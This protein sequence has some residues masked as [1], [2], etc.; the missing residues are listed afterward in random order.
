MFNDEELGRAKPVTITNITLTGIDAGNYIPNTTAVS[1]GDITVRAISAS[2]PV[3]IDSTPLSDSTPSVLIGDLVPLVDTTVTFTRTGFPSVVCSFIPQSVTETCTT[4]GLADGTWTYRARQ[5]IAGLMVAASEQ[6]TITIDTT[7]PLVTKPVSFTVASDSGPNSTDGITN[8][9][10]PTVSVSEASPTDTVVVIATSNA[11]TKQCTFT[12]TA[13][14]RT[15]T[16]P[17]LLDGNWAISAVISD[18]AQNSS[19]STPVFNVMI[20][21]IVPV[22]GATPFNAQDNGALTSLD[23]TP[24][25]SVTGVTPGEI[26]TIKGTRSGSDIASC[27]FVAS[28]TVS[29]CDMSPMASGT[30]SLTSTISDLAGNVSPPSAPLTIIISAGKAPMTI[31]RSTLRPVAGTNK[32]EKVVAVKFGTSAALAGIQSVSFIVFDGNGAVVRRTTVKINPNDTGTQIVIPRA[33]KGATVRVITTNQCG[34]SEGAP[35]SFNVR[36]GQTSISI[37]KKTNIPTL[38]GQ[39]VLPQIDF[40]ASEITLDAGDKAQLD[41]AMKD[42]KG[43]CGTLLVSGYSRQ[44]NV[45]SRRYLQNLADFRAQA[46]A[47]YLSGK[48]LTMWISYQGFIIRPAAGDTETYRRVSVYWTPS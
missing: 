14:E 12:A 47:N 18:S 37:D 13:S 7:A 36:S 21:T 10:S 16:L 29:S 24:R 6:L 39:L 2:I 23:A 3:A 25:I 27:S 8:D 28:A 33:I 20:D 44:N 22:A 38:N 19:T 42:M 5:L 1:S 32:F 40:A 43:K 30:W 11:Q 4:Q 35:R 46:V 9:N 41:K 26:A 15:C 48:G 45:D 31:A 34:V 17:T